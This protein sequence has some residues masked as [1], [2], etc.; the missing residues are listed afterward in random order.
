MGLLLRGRIDGGGS[1]THR[2]DITADADSQAQSENNDPVLLIDPW[3]I[4]VIVI[5]ALIIVSLVSVIAVLYVRARRRKQEAKQADPI[6]HEYTRRRKNQPDRLGADELER[7][8]MIRKSL[9]SRTSNRH[10]QNSSILPDH[11]LMEAMDE[12]AEKA[13]LREDWKDREAGLQ[14]EKESPRTPDAEP[15][16][17]TPVFFPPRLPLPMISRTP[18]P[19]RGVLPPRK[20]TPPPQFF[21]TQL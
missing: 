15:R 10:S 5:G 20:N 17:H 7:A 2:Q 12:A 4:V 6:S 8:V 9:A 11:R 13:S 14:T 1:L 3:V 19:V 16:G 21:F 18:S